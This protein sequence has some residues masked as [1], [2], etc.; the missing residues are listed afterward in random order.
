MKNRLI[1]K[2]TLSPHLGKIKHIPSSK[3]FGNHIILGGFR[4]K[5][6]LGVFFML[7]KFHRRVD[8]GLSS[9]IDTL[10]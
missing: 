9:T 2:G 6:S 4:L 7:F 8:D 3:P 5:W 10:G 1:A